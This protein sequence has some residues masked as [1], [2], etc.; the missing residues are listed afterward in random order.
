MIEKIRNDPYQG[1]GTAKVYVYEEFVPPAVSLIIDPITKETKH[2][3]PRGNSLEIK[4]EKYIV[5][6]V[7]RGVKRKMEIYESKFDERGEKIICFIYTPSKSYC[8]HY[9]QLIIDLEPHI[10]YYRVLGF[11]FHPET[12]LTYPG[13]RM[14]IYFDNIK[15]GPALDFFDNVDIKIL[16]NEK[17]KIIKISTKP[18]NSY[19]EDIL[20]SKIMFRPLKLYYKHT[21]KIDNVEESYEVEWKK[22][23]NFVYPIEV[24][25]KRWTKDIN[26]PDLPHTL[27]KEIKILNFDPETEVNDK[28]FEI[29]SVKLPKGIQVND[30]LLGTTYK[31]P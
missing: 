10:F 2:I 3:K 27:I 1:K 13:T 30:R 7:F 18:V 6:F 14:L 8:Y 31:L 4:K 25:L 22:Y 23:K 12:F 20:D 29:E 5:D 11:D 28:E 17:V 24:K 26:E 19:S 9:N 16:D 21:S 15:N